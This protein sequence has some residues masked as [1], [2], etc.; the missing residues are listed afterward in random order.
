[1]RHQR[2]SLSFAILGGRSHG[3]GVVAFRQRRHRLVIPITLRRQRRRWHDA[4]KIELPPITPWLCSPSTDG[5]ISPRQSLPTTAVQNRGSI[6]AMAFER[7]IQNL[8]VVAQQMMD[9][10]RQ[11]PSLRHCTSMNEHCGERLQR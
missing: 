6:G 11:M 7:P 4:R 10:G 5:G 8:S 2:A 3:V 1:V 9:A